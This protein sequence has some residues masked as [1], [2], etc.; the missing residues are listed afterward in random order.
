MTIPLCCSW[1]THARI[2]YMKLDLMVTKLVLSCMLQHAWVSMSTHRIMIKSPVHELAVVFTDRVA[3]AKQGDN[4][5]GSFCPS[6]L[7]SENF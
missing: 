6:R 4:A 1:G 7:H 2:G 3:L 5:L